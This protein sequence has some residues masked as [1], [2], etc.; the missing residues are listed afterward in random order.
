MSNYIFNSKL[1]SG[2]NIIV[3]LCSYNGYNT[4]DS[5]IINK[6]SLEKGLFI[7]SYFKVYEAEERIDKRETKK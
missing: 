3:A 4:E 2:N 5:V 1:P 7:S 6:S